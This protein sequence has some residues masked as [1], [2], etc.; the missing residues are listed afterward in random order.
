MIAVN[1][2]STSQHNLESF[3]L[4]AHFV[5]ATLSQ[6][7]SVPSSVVV[8]FCSHR[9]SPPPSHSDVIRWSCFDEFNRIEIEVLSV[10]AQQLITIKTAIDSGA[11]Q[12]IFEGTLL[13]L[14]PTCCS[15]V[16]AFLL[17]QSFSCCCIPSNFTDN[18]I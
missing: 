14:N 10:I 18:Y 3:Q 6:V 1:V 12:F 5:T 9:I 11:K 17:L 13:D 8:Q 4:S 2:L 7:C 15:C 16:E